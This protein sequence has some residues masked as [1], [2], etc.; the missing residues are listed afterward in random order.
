MAEPRTG[1]EYFVEGDVTPEAT[2]GVAWNVFGFGFAPN[3]TTWQQN[4]PPGTPVEAT[5]H[6]VGASPTGAW[7]GNAGKLA[8]YENASWRF[9]TPRNGM[10]VYRV[11]ASSKHLQGLWCYDETDGWFP[12]W[13]MWTTTEHWTGRYVGLA[14]D[15]ESTPA[16]VWRKC[17]NIAAFPGPGTN[18]LNV[19]Y[20]GGLVIDRTYPISLELLAVNAGA[21]SI[22]VPAP[23]GG[24][25]LDIVLYSTTCDL[26]AVAD[27][28]AYSGTLLIEYVKDI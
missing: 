13:R 2:L 22:P 26:V 23:I 7:S 17:I 3:I 14:A 21:N 25:P 24:L 11:E 20:G 10:R 6:I 19:S 16:K 1:L 8:R 28:S 12:T 9:I 27:M 18:P 15:I 4:A 5:W